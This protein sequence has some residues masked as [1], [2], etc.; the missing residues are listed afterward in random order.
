MQPFQVCQRLF[1]YLEIVFIRI[2]CHT[3]RFRYVLNLNIAIVYIMY[4]LCAA[5]MRHYTIVFIVN[6]L[7]QPTKV[8]ANIS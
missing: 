5:V 6:A 8:N 3:V 4:R 2:D 7:C 1:L